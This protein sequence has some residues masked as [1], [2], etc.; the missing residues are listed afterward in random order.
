M[1]QSEQINEA[2]IHQQITERTQ[3]LRSAY[4]NHQLLKYL[5][6]LV[7]VTATAGNPHSLDLY[8]M[9]M[10][11]NRRN[12]STQP[13]NSFEV[14]TFLWDTAVFIVTKLQSNASPEQD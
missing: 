7:I 8:N 4:N 13:P 1:V 12:K 2:A 14:E 10:D 3:E 5:N 6:Q 9:A 11:F